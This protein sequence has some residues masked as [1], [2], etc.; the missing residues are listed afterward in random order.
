[1]VPDKPVNKG[2]G[3]PEA[4]RHYNEATQDFVESEKVQEQEED[5]RNI[6]ESEKKKLEEA[7][8]TGA[9]HAKEEDPAVKR[10]Y[11]KPED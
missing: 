7:E 10:D 8:K 2:E 3:D 6:P 4:A 9:E 1:M 5:R 11:S